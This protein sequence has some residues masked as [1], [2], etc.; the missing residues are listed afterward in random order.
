MSEFQTGFIKGY[1]TTDHIFVLRLVI[2]NY[3]KRCKKGILAAFIDFS[4]AFDR[5]WRD[6]PVL[7]LPQSRVRGRIIK[8]IENMYRTTEYGVKCQGGITPFFLVPL[9]SGKD[10]TLADVIQY[11]YQ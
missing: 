5:I 9:A 6:A 3:V 7:K 10:V 4:K 11:F 8:I 1:R 2:D